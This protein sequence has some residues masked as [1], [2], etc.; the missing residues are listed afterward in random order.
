MTSRY[1]D[2]PPLLWIELMMEHVA[3]GATGCGPS[4]RSNLLVSAANTG[5]DC[6]FWDITYSIWDTSVDISVA[7]TW[8]FLDVD[9]CTLPILAD[10]LADTRTF[11]ALLPSFQHHQYRVLEFSS[12][13]HSGAMVNPA[14]TEDAVNT[15]AVAWVLTS[16]SSTAYVFLV[17]SIVSMG[18]MALI[19]AAFGYSWAFGEYGSSSDTLVYSL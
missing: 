15:D 19:W 8:C 5:C 17:V 7:D 3:V 14:L 1:L 4:N 12:R 2:I 9:D 13:G 10:V 16:T 18:I 11:V 6:E